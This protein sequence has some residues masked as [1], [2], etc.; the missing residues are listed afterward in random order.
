MVRG[1]QSMSRT[2]G[3]REF[4]L[5]LQLLGREALPLAVLA[6][7]FGDRPGRGEVLRGS[8]GSMAGRKAVASNRATPE[9]VRNDELTRSLVP[10]EADA[11]AADTQAIFRRSLVGELDDVASARLGE[12]RD[13][14]DDP[15][16]NRRIETT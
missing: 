5:P 2:A 10:G 7:G 13:G 16:A 14:G 12:V 11:P 4:E 9:D 6:P 1:L 8:N 3:S 15:G